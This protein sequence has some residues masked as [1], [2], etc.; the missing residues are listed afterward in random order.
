MSFYDKILFFVIFPGAAPFGYFPNLVNYGIVINGIFG[1]GLNS[2]VEKPQF[3]R[4]R[5]DFQNFGDFFDSQ[6]FHV[7][8]IA[9]FLRKINTFELKVVDKTFNL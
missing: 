8:N 3:S 9:N 5:A 6:S 7:I 2:G 4:R 1:F